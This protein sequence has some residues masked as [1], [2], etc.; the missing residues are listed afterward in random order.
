MLPRQISPAF[1]GAEFPASAE[2]HHDH[3]GEKGK[4]YLCKDRADEIANSESALIL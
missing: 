3:T 4:N 2:P 1:I